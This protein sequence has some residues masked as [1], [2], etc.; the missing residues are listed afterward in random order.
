MYVK[1][2]R[3][4]YHTLKKCPNVLHFGILN[5]EDMSN[6]T[7][8]VHTTVCRRGDFFLLLLDF[9]QK[10]GVLGPPTL[11]MLPPSLDTGDA[12]KIKRQKISIKFARQLF[13]MH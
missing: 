8:A 6:H 11:K 4:A 1:L 12:L 7:Y 10:I 5:S 13:K 3:Q 9:G 2:N